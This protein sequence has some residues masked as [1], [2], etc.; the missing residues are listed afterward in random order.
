MLDTIV[1]GGGLAGLSAAIWLARYG[2]RVRVY[3]TGEPRNEPTWAVHGYPG[4]PDPPP[5]ELRRRLRDQAVGAGAEILPGEAVDVEG[6]KDAFRV[7][8]ADGSAATSRRVV[9]A[10][11][12]HDLVPDI[13]GIEHLYGRSVFHCP[14]CDGPSLA[15][16]RVGVIG[17][18]R[19][20][21]NVALYL[22]YWTDQLM[23]LTHGEP[24]G[25]DDGQRRAL[26]ENGVAVRTE[27]IERATERNGLLSGVVLEGGGEIPLEGLFFHR[28]SVPACEVAE[29]LGCA[30]DER[31]YLHTDRSGETTVPGVY[32][33]GDIT[34]F[35]HLAIRAASEGVLT[36]LSI[37]RSLLPGRLR[38][39]EG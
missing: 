9:L 16:A 17:S 4:I 12:R 30:C 19:H 20:A 33:A 26:E 31:G 5:L 34:G 3:D 28:G 13:P 7:R 15:G 14:D 32:A 29:R 38:L 8:L 36:A 35:P 1:I 2:R 11:G 24:D 27:R 22:R 23:L 21:A 37:H 18:D 39:E 10:F 6:E 25:L